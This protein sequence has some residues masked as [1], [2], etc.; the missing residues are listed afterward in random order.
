MSQDDVYR[1][2]GSPVLVEYVFSNNPMDYISEPVT[3]EPAPQQIE[4]WSYDSK[5]G[6]DSQIAGT[7]S[8]TGMSLLYFF[9]N[10]LT[11][12][13]WIAGNGSANDT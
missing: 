9:N 10:R 2:F 7:A 11:R 1:E 5:S 6:G 3:G 12:T 4:I 8:N 13:D